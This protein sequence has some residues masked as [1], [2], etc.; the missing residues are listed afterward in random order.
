MTVAPRIPRPPFLHPH[1]HGP[2]EATG[3]P[4]R[5]GVVATGSIAEKVTPEIEMLPDALLHA[6]SSRYAAKAEAFAHR[7]GFERFYYDDDDGTG[8]ERLVADPAIDVVYVT[9]PHAQHFEVMRAAVQAGKH[10][11]CE[12]PFSITAAEAEQLFKLAHA[13]KVFVMEAV[14]TRFLPSVNRAWEIIAGGELGEIQW[15]QADL[16]FPASYDRHSRLWAP[17]SGGGAL[18]DL[19]VYPLTWVLGSLGFPDAVSATAHLDG[20]GVDDQTA[21][22][23]AY[24]SGAHAQVTC[25]LTGYGPGTAT[26]VGTE[27]RLRAGAPL[28]SPQELTIELHS[29]EARAETF[30]HTGRGYVYEMREVTRCI[31]QGLTQSPTM[32]WDETLQTMRLLDGVRSQ[33][34]LQYANDKNT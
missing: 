6:V 10:V 27:G 21:M 26:I 9:T 34:G 15:I 1:G 12:K 4:L 11:L 30:K 2:L 25:S 3:E 31:H 32:P 22:T 29:R 8:F 24:G 7:F 16:G 14:W 17:E 20:D 5:W 13:K 18:L 28:H 33:I 19:A 23:L